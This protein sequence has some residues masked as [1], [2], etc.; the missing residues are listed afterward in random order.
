MKYKKKAKVSKPLKKAAR[1]KTS[2]KEY[3]VT[4]FPDGRWA[5]TYLKK[6]ETKQEMRKPLRRNTFIIYALSRRDAIKRLRTGAYEKG[7]F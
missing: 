1:G 5:L 3:A 2:L 4:D 6:G 7:R